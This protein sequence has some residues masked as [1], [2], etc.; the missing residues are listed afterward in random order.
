VTNP[1]VLVLS[2][3]ISA[4]FGLFSGLLGRLVEEW[5][6]RP[7]LVVEFIPEEGGFRTEGTWKNEDGTQI[8]EIYIRA[9]VR[10][11]GRRIAKKCRPYMI[12][13]EE[14]HTSGTT[15]TPFCD[16]AVLRWP[17]ADYEPRDIPNGINC[18][19]DVVGVL[20]NRPGWRF[21]FSEKEMVSDYAALP[22]YEGTYRFTVLVTG[23]GV[24]PEG[25]KI[26]VTYN[27]NSN[28]LRAVDA[29]ELD[30]NLRRQRRA[31]G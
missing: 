10:N 22:K 8:T 7:R 31:A 14:V 27:G 23:D 2:A 3:V 21:K 17:R 16:S 11:V 20:K 6:Y 1:W 28:N 18:F 29:G 4:V 19:F 9:R 13:L 24:E 12:R 30:A 25:R 15:Q 5:R 26:D